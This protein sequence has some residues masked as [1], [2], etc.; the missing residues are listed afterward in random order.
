MDLPDIR[1]VSKKSVSDWVIVL[2]NVWL[3]TILILLLYGYVHGIPSSKV[4]LLFKKIIV[5]CWT[6][7]YQSIWLDL[8]WLD[9]YCL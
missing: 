3:A 7:L 6:Y 8:T 5:V 2:Y 1:G 9:L 4:L